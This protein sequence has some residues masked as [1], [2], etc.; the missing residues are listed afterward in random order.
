M[1][2]PVVSL[3]EARGKK[4]LKRLMQ[5]CAEERFM[6]ASLP[7]LDMFYTCVDAVLGVVDPQDRRA[8]RRRLAE[9][10][11]IP[12]QLRGNRPA[13][14]KWIDFVIEETERQLG[15]LTG[16]PINRTSDH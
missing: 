11:V 12:A 3:V 2:T 7:A 14:E 4:T 1:I 13:Y 8:V 15:V 16:Q 5:A 9:A 6:R 10:N